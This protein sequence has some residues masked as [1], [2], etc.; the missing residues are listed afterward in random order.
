V[1]TLSRGVALQIVGL[2]AVLLSGFLLCTTHL[3]L[4]WVVAGGSMQPSLLHGDRV[5][6]DLW[7]YGCR[8]PRPGEIV[9]FLGPP[10]QQLPLVKRVAASSPAGASKVS[11]R[12]WGM[13]RGAPGDG[14]WMIGDNRSS[15]EDSRRF[16][17]VPRDAVVGR[18]V[19]RYWPPSRAGRLR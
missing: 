10:P 8:E 9:L 18:V 12:V 4:P 17:A 14:L 13:D 1:N 16:G 15:S 11:P 6:V 2:F 5:I 3:A 7:T 19:W